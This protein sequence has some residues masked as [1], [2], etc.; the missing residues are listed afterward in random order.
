MDNI[1]EILAERSSH[2][3]RCHGDRTQYRIN[4]DYRKSL[5]TEMLDTA[6]RFLGGYFGIIQ[7]A[8]ELSRFRPKPLL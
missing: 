7:T 5:R 2:I 8:R 6:T 3:G 1:D 4:L